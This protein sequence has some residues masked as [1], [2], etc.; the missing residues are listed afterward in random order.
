[1]TETEHKV[2]RSVLDTLSGTKIDLHV[3]RHTS[4]PDALELYNYGSLGKT[5]LALRMLSELL[6][7]Q[8]YFLLPGE[9]CDDDTT[10]D[11][12]RVYTPGDRSDFDEPL[13][14][15]EKRWL[16]QVLLVVMNGVSGIDDGDDACLRVARRK[17]AEVAG[18]PFLNHYRLMM[19][20][21]VK[22]KFFFEYT[23]LVDF[24]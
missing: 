4:K 24:A 13:T 22:P 6:G 10:L 14:N 5:L 8:F 23:P 18:Y 15:S 21:T 9:Y 2:L 11:D 12:L 7:R 3:Y 19:E 20:D 17:V 16:I 1:M